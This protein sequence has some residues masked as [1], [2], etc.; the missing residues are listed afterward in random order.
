MYV[1]DMVQVVKG[2]YKFCI[3]TVISITDDLIVLVDVDGELV[4][5]C[6]V[7]DIHALTE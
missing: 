6:E 1:G 5:S 7:T 4:I 2:K 3:G